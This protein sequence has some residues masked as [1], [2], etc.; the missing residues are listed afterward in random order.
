MVLNQL[1][2][3]R[4]E[5][6]LNQLCTPLPLSCPF[7]SPPRSFLFRF[8]LFSPDFA[9]F[10]IFTLNIYP[11]SFICLSVY[12]LV[13]L[14]LILSLPFPLYLFPSLLF[15]SVFLNSKPT[16]ISIKTKSCIDYRITTCNF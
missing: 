7:C 4:A 1:I 14:S 12:L 2:Y 15:L 3:W 16:P 13:D 6:T 5:I 10:F 11:A 8:P 9:F